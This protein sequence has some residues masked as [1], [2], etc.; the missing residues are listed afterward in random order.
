LDAR[1]SLEKVVPALL[2]WH[3]LTSCDIPYNHCLFRQRFCSGG[4]VCRRSI[5]LA[6]WKLP[7][8]HLESASKSRLLEGTHE[9]AWYHQ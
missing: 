3:P 6:S 5:L 4:R 7:L 1:F 8:P 9:V 2:P